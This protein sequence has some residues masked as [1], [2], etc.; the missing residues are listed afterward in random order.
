MGRTIWARS[1][2]HGPYLSTLL[3]PAWVSG[4]ISLVGASRWPPLSLPSASSECRVGIWSAGQ[5]LQS[6]T[7]ADQQ[8]RVFLGRRPS[9]RRQVACHSGGQLS[10]CHEVGVS[11]STEHPPPL[12]CGV[13][14]EGGRSGSLTSGKRISPGTKTR[15]LRVNPQVAGHL[16]WRS[17]C[18][19]LGSQGRPREVKASSLADCPGQNRL[20]VLMGQLLVF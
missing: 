16:G 19:A 1:V 5:D 15:G 20:Q 8:R 2:I 11:Q 6:G 14:Q 9:K 18:K 4:P 17:R 12:F 13:S 7:T 10:L 3:S